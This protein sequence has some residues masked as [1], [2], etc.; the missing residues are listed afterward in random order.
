V[1]HG[2]VTGKLPAMI[3]TGNFKNTSCDAMMT[4]MTM[5]MMMMMMVECQ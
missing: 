2:S 1:S 4:M 3:V 5:M